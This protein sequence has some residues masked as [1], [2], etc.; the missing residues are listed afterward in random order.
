MNKAINII[1]KELSNP[2]FFINDYCKEMGMSRSSV[3]N[4]IKIITGQSI[5]DFIRLIR[6]N[7]AR[8]LLK[9]KKHNISEIA[10]LVGFSDAK[11]FSTAFRKQFGKSPSKFAG[12]T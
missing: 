8:K 3:Y 4:K 5:S 6:L 11:Y 7:K 10:I 9:S 12:D 2:D 1:E